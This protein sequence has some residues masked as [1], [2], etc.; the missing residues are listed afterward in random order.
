MAAPVDC[1]SVGGSHPLGLGLGW[2]QDSV[3]A[4][5]ASKREAAQAGTLVR[6]SLVPGDRPEPERPEVPRKWEP[7]DRL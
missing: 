4:V 7:G 1:R 3:L 6:C 5:A 2:A